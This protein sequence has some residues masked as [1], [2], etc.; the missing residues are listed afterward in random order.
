[1]VRFVAAISYSLYLC[2]FS[3]G[4]G[5]LLLL[6]LAAPPLIVI[7]PFVYLALNLGIATVVYYAFERPILNWRDRPRSG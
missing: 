5:L 6:L 3:V 7:G 1:M 4:R 2:H